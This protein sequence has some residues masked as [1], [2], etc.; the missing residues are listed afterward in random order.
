[1]AGEEI[2]DLD[3]LESAPDTLLTIARVSTTL[4][5]ERKHLGFGNLGGELATL[6]EILQ[7]FDSSL[8]QE[9]FKRRIRKLLK[10]LARACTWHREEPS[11]DFTFL[12]HL[13]ELPQ[14]L[15]EGDDEMKAGLLAYASAEKL[16][17]LVAL[18]RNFAGKGFQSE[19]A[20]YSTQSFTRHRSELATS[21]SVYPK[22]VSQQLYQT[23]RKYSA[24]QCVSETNNNAGPVLEKTHLSRLRLRPSRDVKET[25]V[26]FDMVFSSLPPSSLALKRVEWQH[27]Q[28][29]VC[30][31]RPGKKRARFSDQETSVDHPGRPPTS[32][33]GVQLCNQLISPSGSQICLHV[34]KDQLWLLEDCLPLEVHV[35]AFPS[36]SLS[37]ALRI[38]RLSHEMKVIL[39]YIIAKSVWEFYDS[40]WMSRPWSAEDI[41]FMQEKPGNKRGEP[42]ISINRPYLAVR[43]GEGD[44]RESESSNIVGQIHRYP[45][46]L[47]LGWILIEIATGKRARDL[48]QNDQVNVNSDWLSA[49]EFLSRTSPW[50]EFDYKNYWDAARNCFNNQFF[51]KGAMSSIGKETFVDIESR[52]RMIMEEVVT[53]LEALLT[54]TGWIHDIWTV[55]PLKP[56]TARSTPA[57]GELLVEGPD[58]PRHY[59]IQPRSNATGASQSDVVLDTISQTVASN[60]PTTHLRPRTRRDFEIGIICALP[61]EVDAVF[62]LF[63]EY[64]DDENHRYGKAAKDPN[65]YT[66]GRIGHHNVVVAHMPSLGKVS[67]ASVAQGLQSSF[68]NI[69]LVLVVGICGG[70]PYNHR[71][72]R[73]VFLGDVIISRSLVQYDYGR[74]YPIDFERKDCL[75]GESGKSSHEVR[76]LLAKLETAHHR[77]HLE[78]NTNRFLRVVQGTDKKTAYP[79]AETDKLFECSSLHQHYVAGSCQTCRWESDVRIC[80]KAIDSSCEEL[81]YETN[82]LVHRIRLPNKAPPADPVGEQGLY[83]PSIHIGNMGSGDTVMKSGTH[84]DKIAQKYD[85]L[86]FEMEGAGI[87]DFFPSLVIKAVSDYSDSH[88]NKKWQV[89]AA[90]AAAAATKAFL[91]E[92]RPRSDSYV[93]QLV[94]PRPLM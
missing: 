61:S 23:L 7:G 28:F 44:D 94:D 76:S 3:L 12:L 42:L 77:R 79:G 53:P 45:K 33:T 64:W 15:S 13:V 38:G 46:I 73:E 5:I 49:R 57:A 1:M 40:D 62:L 54:G 8:Q 37:D 83:R 89:Y 52:R 67:A 35:L 20:Q 92:W 56:S 69:Q 81:G 16:P 24:C 17:K 21:Q 26:C 6:S 41:H 30:S 72:K 78:Y 10:E 50:D 87:W 58:R 88:K 22:H 82:G 43:W 60:R 4:G 48:S 70:V 91:E 71:S 39:A 11:E 63:D 85:I 34:D 86:G 19:T 2:D 25:F 93:D 18:V 29:Q 32:A 36:L 27:L 47:S 66:T 55:G 9:K 51:L 84:R 90:A 14:S 75:E 59:L 31:E 74:Q 65:A 68:Q 80:Q